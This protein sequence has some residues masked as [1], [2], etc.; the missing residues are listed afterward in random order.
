MLIAGE[1]AWLMCP[2]VHELLNCLTEPHSR[3][4]PHGLALPDGLAQHD[5]IGI[6]LVACSGVSLAS[7]GARRS[8]RDLLPCLPRHCGLRDNIFRRVVWGSLPA[9]GGC[10]ATPLKCTAGPVVI[11]LQA[12]VAGRALVR[13]GTLPVAQWATASARATRA[14]RSYMNWRHSHCYDYCGAAPWKGS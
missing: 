11:R 9:N 5:Q 4:V 12:I 13:A 6:Y 1:N 3:A 8:A 7:R 10:D 2:C 14:G